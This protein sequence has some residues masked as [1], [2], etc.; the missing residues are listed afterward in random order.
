MKA[1]FGTISSRLPRGGPWTETRTRTPESDD[2]SK[3]AD[4][5]SKK[6]GN[7]QAGNAENGQDRATE[8]RRANTPTSD[9]CGMQAETEET[10]CQK[11]DEG[12]PNDQ[13]D[14]MAG[15]IAELEKQVH[16]L[17]EYKHE[18]R[19]WRDCCRVETQK[20]RDA[21]A[22][23]DNGRR[24]YQALHD[25]ANAMLAESKRCYAALKRDASTELAKKN[26]VINRLQE[27][28]QAKLAEKDKIIA[29]LQ[30]EALSHVDRHE[31]AFDSTVADAFSKVNRKIGALVRRSAAISSNVRAGGEETTKA[32]TLDAFA[33]ALPLEHWGERMVKPEWY[34]SRI[35]K[36]SQSDS[37][38]RALMLRA[39]IWK[40]LAAELFDYKRPFACLASEEARHL[41]MDYMAVF[42]D[43]A[44]SQA[45]A[46][47]RA[48]T[49]KCLVDFE[50]KDPRF[51]KDVLGRLKNAF[52]QLLHAEIAPKI[53]ARP[54]MT[55]EHVC[56]IVAGGMGR[57]LEPVLQAAVELATITSQ[58]RA[59]YRLEFP[60]LEQ[61][62]YRK[63]AEDSFMTT[64]PTPLGINARVADDDGDEEGPV[65][66]IASP[67]LVKWGNGAGERLGEHTVLCKAFAWRPNRDWA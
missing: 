66:L 44:S 30:K 26:S 14:S 6:L 55:F 17:N 53:D 5:A 23:R 67:A 8:D 39:M 19:S 56:R 38:V 48:L 9:C 27:E 62:R 59:L 11:D 64:D 35:V 13:R 7:I 21:E 46:K 20:L 65:V 31:P 15:Y 60:N 37:A 47:W 63:A 29:K 45:T 54:L 10:S 18:V 42:P 1:M 41:G 28:A 57:E 24:A 34:D 3:G 61:S 36:A 52:A 25:E 40:F 51:Q 50:A 2:N 16:Q 33:E 32:I 43:P 58:E 12:N 22:E 4:I 49:A